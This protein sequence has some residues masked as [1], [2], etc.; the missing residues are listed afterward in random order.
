MPPLSNQTRQVT[1]LL[2]GALLG[3]GLI[4]WGSSDVHGKFVFLSIFGVIALYLS[5]VRLTWGLMFLAVAML[6]SPELTLAGG[7]AQGG[8]EVTRP[9]VLRVDDFLIATLAVG[10]A[11]KSAYQGEAYAIAWTPINKAVWLYIAISVSATILGFIR[12]DVHFRSG[13]FYN[14]KYFEYFLLYLM[15]LGIIKDRRQV[16]RL[17]RVMLL[18]FLVVA[19]YGLTQVPS[20]TR[21]LAPFDKEPNTLSGY[22]LLIGSVAVGVA[23]HAR[24]RP[25]R[26][27]CYG[28]VALAFI[29]FLFTRSRGGYLGLVVAYGAFLFYGKQRW[30]LFLGGC[31][32]LAL[33]G[34]GW[35]KLPQSVV[36]R[37]RYTFSGET[38]RGVEQFE[39][40]GLELDPSTSAR[41]SSYKFAMK[42]W[43]RHPI[44]GVGV[45]GT[46]F[47]DGQYFRL[48]AE[49]GAFGLG[50]FI[51]L[52][53]S[54]YGALVIV[55]RRSPDDSIFKGIS[56]GV[57]CA[58]FGLA[59]HAF[60][61]N[62][63]IIIRIAEPFWLLVGVVL[64]G[65]RFDGW[66]SGFLK[67]YHHGDSDLA[68]PDREGQSAQDVGG[69][70]SPGDGLRPGP[71]PRPVF[72]GPSPAPIGSIR[73]LAMNR[74]RR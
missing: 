60:A 48:L 50:S 26:W 53:W 63:F 70:G 2:V 67:S 20:G 22:F 30:R 59:A 9:V 56:L 66:Q 10:W 65:P 39:V 69:P 28:T 6:L 71:G 24:S 51:Y 19:L 3:I 32:V 58:F 18:V 11:I 49:T 25:L 33:I 45:T 43:L 37:I 41:L 54:I 14:L 74:W 31:V 38:Q 29:P 52:L 72:P 42:E 57:L 36:D 27:F 8:M 61:A 44:L 62:T 17:L 73:G 40:G 7:S 68:S 21:V 47:I 55:Y 16:E 12:G 35:V 23:L 1:V 5:F 13:F 34:I 64:L 4:A 15:V 46:S